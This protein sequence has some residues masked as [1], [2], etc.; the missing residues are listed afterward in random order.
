MINLITRKYK[1][2]T[3]HNV[4]GSQNYNGVFCVDNK[5]TIINGKFSIYLKLNCPKFGNE[6]QFQ[7]VS[8]KD[9]KVVTEER[10]NSSWNT[11][12]IDLDTSE[13]EKLIEALQKFKEILK[14]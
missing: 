11:I 5:R 8:H 9:N 6:L 4:Y 12:E 1:D 14:K 3:F 2:S 7:L 10:N 13:I